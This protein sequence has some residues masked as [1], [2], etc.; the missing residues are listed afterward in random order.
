MVHFGPSEYA[1]YDEA[2][3]HI[4]QTGSLREYQ[5]EF[6]RLASRVNDWL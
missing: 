6:K 4:K 3:V 5:K 1:D 2:L